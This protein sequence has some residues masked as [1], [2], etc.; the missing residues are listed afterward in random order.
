MSTIRFIL[1]LLVGATL[2]A[3]AL[4]FIAMSLSLILPFIVFGFSIL[5]L[6]LAFVLF[7][8]GAKVTSDCWKSYFSDDGKQDRRRNRTFKKL[9]KERL[10]ILAVE[11]ANEAERARVRLLESSVNEGKDTDQSWLS[12]EKTFSGKL[13]F[14]R[15]FQECSFCQNSTGQTISGIFVC[16]KCKSRYDDAM[17]RKLKKLF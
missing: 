11:Q 7:F 1:T 6:W 17:S 8:G 15:K 5:A 3:V 10:K 2:I 12:C 13:N 14:S 9:E 16:N 4:G